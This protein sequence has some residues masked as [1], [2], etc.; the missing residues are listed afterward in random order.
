MDVGPAVDV[1]VIESL[2][3]WFGQDRVDQFTALFRTFDDE[4]EVMIAAAEACAG[5][6]DRLAVTRIA[7]KLLGSSATI[8]ARSLA[9]LCTQIEAGI[10]SD[11]AWVELLGKISRLPAEQR[12]FSTERSLLLASEEAPGN[13]SGGLPKTD[14]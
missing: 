11:E 14:G 3:A 1:A 12:R 8:G 9:Q 13:E 5:R 2:R 10:E 4:A 7:H 6:D